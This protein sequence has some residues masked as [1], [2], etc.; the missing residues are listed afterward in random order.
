MPRQPPVDDVYISSGTTIAVAGSRQFFRAVDYDA[1]MAI[2]RAAPMQSYALW[3]GHRNGRQRPFLYPLQL[4]EGRG[5]TGPLDLGLHL[6][7]Y[8]PPVATH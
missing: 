2:A 3:N 4:G 1:A 5:R 7:R 6:P 8:R